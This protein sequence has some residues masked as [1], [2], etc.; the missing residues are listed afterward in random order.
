MATAR[1][2]AHD[3]LAQVEH[4][5]RRATPRSTTRI[6]KASSTRYHD[7]LISVSSGGG[8]GRSSLLRQWLRWWWKRDGGG[9]RRSPGQGGTPQGG[10]ISP[11]LAI[12]TALLDTRFHRAAARRVGQGSLVRYADDFVIMARYIDIASSDGWNGPW[13]GAWP[14]DQ[15]KKT[16]VI[17][18]TRRGCHVGV[19]RYSFG[20]ELGYTLGRGRFLTIEPR[21]GAIS[22]RKAELRKT[23]RAADV[24][25]RPEWFRPSTSS[26]AAG[27][28]TSA[29]GFLAGRTNGECLRDRASYDSPAASEP[30]PLPTTA[31]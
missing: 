14:H 25:C 12:S 5:L 3:A 2:S 1:R 13:K 23:T 15:R 21:R 9:G 30:A 27:V 29:S 16:R 31:G 18:L 22:H 24:S 19:S 28:T 17:T 6:C 7:N 11:L 20:Y 26:S 8:E 4:N 10:I